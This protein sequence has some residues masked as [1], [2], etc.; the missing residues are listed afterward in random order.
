MRLGSDD[1]GGSPKIYTRSPPLPFLVYKVPIFIQKSGFRLVKSL[2][3]NLHRSCSSC[4]M[5]SSC[6]ELPTLRDADRSEEAMEARAHFVRELTS[7]QNMV[8]FPCKLLQLPKSKEDLTFGSS[9][10]AMGNLHCQWR[11]VAGK[12][13]YK[14]VIFRKSKTVIQHPA[15]LAMWIFWHAIRMMDVDSWRKCWEGC[16]L[17]GYGAILEEKKRGHL[18]YGSKS[19]NPWN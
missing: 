11:C 9:N 6:H 3:S 7:I 5:V 12:I 8:V 16:C 1:F 18:G 14:S 17:F 19:L 13:H 15:S 4:W 2:V 10:A